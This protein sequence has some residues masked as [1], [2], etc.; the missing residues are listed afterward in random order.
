MQ[1]KTYADAVKLYPGCMLGHHVQGFLVAGLC[2]IGSP[3]Y[4]VTAGLWTALYIA[5]QGL[6]V[7]R[8]HDS[9]GL[10]CMDFMVG[11]GAGTVVM[12]VLSCFGL[13]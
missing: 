3:T 7:I 6:S 2:A 9:A 5:Y 10:D 8:K 13:F 4:L 12:G 1:R 11:L